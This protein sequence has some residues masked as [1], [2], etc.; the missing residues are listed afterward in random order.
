[1]VN[2]GDLRMKVETIPIEELRISDLNVRA[3]EGFGDEEDAELVK[4]IESL[5]I[6]QPIVVRKV[7]D[8]FEVD[9]GRRR[10]LSA[11]E[12]GM[13]EIPCVVRE[14]S[15]EDSMDASIS[16]NVF[17]RAVDPVTLGRWLKMRLAKG[18]MSMSEYA[19]RIGKA[20]STL[21]E[22]LRMTDL[23][24]EMQEQVKAEAVPFTYALKVARMELSPEEERDLA[25][26]AAEGGFGAFKDKI[27]GLSAS[28][29]TRGAPK[30]LLILRISFGQKSKD[31]NRLKSLAKAKEMELSDYCMDVLKAHIKN[32]ES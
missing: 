22:W 5:G 1:M 3:H 25:R 29:E 9:V 15:D 12:L 16:E 28:R 7:G 31:Y 23:T 2:S 18:D 13:T 14:S 10:F 27:D 30:G 17:R 11:K 26:E 19:R 8:F 6:L 4:N 21:S 20:K 32:P 24:V